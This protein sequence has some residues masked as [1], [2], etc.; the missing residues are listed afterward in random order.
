M[1]RFSLTFNRQHAGRLSIGQFGAICTLI[2]LAAFSGAATAQTENA[3]SLREAREAAQARDQQRLMDFLD[4]QQALEAALEQARAENEEAQQQHETL[5]AQ[6]AEQ[7]EQASELS[8]RQAEQ[9]EALSG[10]LDNLARH[11]SEIRNALG[12]ESLLTLEEGSLPPRLDEVEVLER[13]QLE[14]LVDGL[15]TLTARTGR[16]ERLSMPVADANG[17]VVTRELVRLGDFAAFTE[18]ELVERGQNDGNLVV[19]PRTPSAIGGLLADYYQGESNVFAVDPTQGSVLEAL[20]QQPSLWERFQQGG[21]VGYVVVALGVLGMIVGLGQYLYLV[22]VSLRV[23]RQ[24]QSLDQLRA[25][26]PLGRVLLRF[27]GMDKHQTPEALEA[28]LDEAVLAELPRLERSQPMVKLLA[29][30]AP[31]LGLLGTVT[32]MIVTFQAITV[33]GTG[34]PQLMAGGISQALVTTVLGLITAVPLLFVQTAL[35]GRSRYLTHVIEGQA[36][37]TL[38][39]HLESQTPVVN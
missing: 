35:A 27:E 19:L 8:E 20:A 12:E 24:R 33:F 6:Q 17:E 38:A 15:A 29:A 9:G 5:E 23:K 13:H 16:A 22:L 11:S 36:S 37:A 1:S 32:G 34:D 25:N 30:I 18:S 10:L 14:S 7:T 2:V 39:D 28:R 31:L 26:N 21:Y 4:D 3:T